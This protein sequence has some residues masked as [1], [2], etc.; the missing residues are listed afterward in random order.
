MCFCIVVSTFGM[1]Y[2]NGFRIKANGGQGEKR[3]REKNGRILFPDLFL[4]NAQQKIG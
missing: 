3:K 4:V 1:N 2:P